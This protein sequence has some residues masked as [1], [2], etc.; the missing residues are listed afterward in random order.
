MIASVSETGLTAR[1]SRSPENQFVIN[2]EHVVLRLE[3]DIVDQE[4]II[5]AIEDFVSAE[6]FSPGIGDR[7][8]LELLAQQMS[9]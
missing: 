2:G 1:L 6:A 7:G 8:G 5:A 4:E 3:F 9:V